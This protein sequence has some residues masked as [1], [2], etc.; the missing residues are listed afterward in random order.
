[1]AKSWIRRSINR[2]PPPRRSLSPDA[3]CQT[4]YIDVQRAQAS[5][6][7][8]SAARDSLQS[9][10][11]FS[12]LDLAFFRICSL[13]IFM[14]HL[15]P[16][17][18]S[19]MLLTQAFWYMYQYQNSNQ[20]IRRARL[21]HGRFMKEARVERCYIRELILASCNALRV[22]DSSPIP[23]GRTRHGAPFAFPRME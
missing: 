9:G 19:R 14:C 7:N 11:H 18:T 3:H 23:T 2:S 5:R 16:V 1:M 8:S 21:K 4:D 20:G 10:T 12:L 15:R 13:L 6:S 22:L 17:E